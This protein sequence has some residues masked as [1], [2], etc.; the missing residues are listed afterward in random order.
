MNALRRLWLWFL[1]RVCL[2]KMPPHDTKPLEAPLSGHPY[3]TEKEVTPIVYEEDVW[4]AWNRTYARIE[5][6][7]G[8]EETDLTIMDL[9][10]IPELLREDPD[11][12]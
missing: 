11:E 2:R 12:Q 8:A 4:E 3:R 1:G 5:Q 9:T 6:G 7:R 10:I